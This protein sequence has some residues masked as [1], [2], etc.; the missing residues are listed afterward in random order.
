MV[1]SLFTLALC[2]FFAHA[3]AAQTFVTRSGKVNFFSSTPVEDITAENAQLSASLSPADGSFSFQVPIRGFHF[4]KALMEEH[5][6]DNYLESAQFPNG[7]FT[8]KIV[9]WS[10]AQAD[11]KKHTVQAR[12]TLT[13]HGVAVER[14]IPATVQLVK[15]AWVLSSRFNVPTKAH[16]IPI[17]DFAAEKIAAEIAVT[18]E[19]T[20]ERK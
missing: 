14:T 8:G 16:N 6:N 7:T 12:G 9:G 2:A 10:T 4:E 17:P 13:I 3:A 20:L 18:V 1:R 15:G 5:F 11:G 19:A